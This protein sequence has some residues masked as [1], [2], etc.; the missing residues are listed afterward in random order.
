MATSDHHTSVAAAAASPCFGKS[1]SHAVLQ[2]NASSQMLGNLETPEDFGLG[3]SRVRVHLALLFQI[4]HVSKQAGKP[5]RVF[6]APLPAT[7][8][9]VGM[10]P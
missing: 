1:L 8:V 7:S 3:H 5:T 4:L 10:P 2:V 9:P 6:L